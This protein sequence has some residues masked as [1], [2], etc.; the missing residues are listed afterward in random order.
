MD[1]IISVVIPCYKVKDKIR[2]VIKGIPESVKH[3]IVVDDKCPEQ[4]GDCAAGFGDKRVIV[5]YHEDNKGVGGAVVTGYKKACELESDIIIK[6]DG[7]GQMDSK[8]IPALIEPLLKD[9]ADY[10]KGNRFM[11][12]RALKKMPIIRLIGNSMLSF[13]LKIASGYWNIVDP[14]NGYMAIHRKTLDKLELG[15][16]SE[17]YFFESDMLI[18]LNIINAVVRDVP[19]PAMYGD[20]TSSLKVSR[21]LFQFPLKLLRGFIKRLLLKYFVYDFNMASV[22]MIFGVPL[23]MF[24]V[25]FG[26]WEWFD[27]IVNDR[28]KTAGTIMLVALPIIVS[29]Q[30]LLQAI[31]IDINSVPKRNR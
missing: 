26:A 21:I 11:D 13:L 16:L 7:D 1:T 15:K 17:N 14:T 24:G 5:I 25:S 4:S 19:M 10:T 30:M 2:D 28:P 22:Y 9:E 20:E 12:F 18:N 29:F 23:F 6:M 8:Y 27:S 3:I 31:S